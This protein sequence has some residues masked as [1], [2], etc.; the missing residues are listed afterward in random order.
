M[1]IMMDILPTLE[2]LIDAVANSPEN[3]AVSEYERLE[4]ILSDD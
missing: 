1:G 3:Q 2:E 4:Y